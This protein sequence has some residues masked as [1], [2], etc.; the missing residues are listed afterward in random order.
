MRH[1]TLA[2]HLIFLATGSYAFQAKP[3]D[4][5][6]PVDTSTKSVTSPER[7]VFK[8]DKSVY[9]DNSFKSA[10]ADKVERTDTAYVVQIKPEN[11]PINWSPWYAFKMWSKKDTTVQ[12]ILDFMDYKSRY[13]PKYS[14]DHKEWQRFSTSDFIL[15]VDST[16]VSL[17]L[18]L[19]KKPIWVA[20][21]EI[22]SSTEVG[23]WLQQLK[24][25]G[26]GDLKVA[27]VSKLGRDI[28]VIEFI[29]SP[30]HPTV[31]LLSR[32]HPP[33]V[34]GYLALQPFVERIVLE[35]DSLSKAFLDRYN[36]IIFPLM[37]PDGVDLGHWR[38]NAGGVDL[39][40]DWAYYR[41]PET[42]QV[43]DYLANF[44]MENKSEIVLGLD[45]HS[46]FYDIYYINQDT[47]VSHLPGFSEKWIKRIKEK[48]SDDSAKVSPSGLLTP[49]SKGWFYTQFGAEGI[50][51]EIGDDTDR[52]MI[53]MKGRVSA[54]EMMKLLIGKTY[55]D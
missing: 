33:E 50:T 34:T 11:E 27:G 44:V 29:Q 49:V 28:P 51:Y 38:H 43:A 37:N 19:T 18:K 47:L 40:R 6:E 46:T 35:N 13:W 17:Q 12:V 54:E 48:V 5:P 42:R 16:K 10:H 8:L 9:L 30:Q 24:K 15:G 21:Q 32:Q 41:Q 1:F 23:S 20:A 7:K 3:Y 55:T 25:R 39:N 26:K 53:K 2:I 36:L 14:Y 52:E 31:V 4:F 45:F 22:Q